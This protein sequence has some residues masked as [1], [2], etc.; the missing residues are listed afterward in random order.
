M[1][2]RDPAPIG[3]RCLATAATV[4]AALLALAS[5]PRGDLPLPW[6]LAFTLPGAALCGWSRLTRSPWRRALVAVVLQAGACWGALQV[7]R[8]LE[9]GVV[10]T[11][12]PDSGERY[13]SESHLW[14]A[15]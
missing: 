12:F 11:V 7:A 9:S 4:L 5:L 1:S 15:E 10:V 3:L 8:R 14:N 13:L 2:A 6:M